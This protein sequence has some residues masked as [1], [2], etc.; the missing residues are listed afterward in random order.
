MALSSRLK[1]WEQKIKDEKKPLPATQPPPSVSVVPGGFL[2]QL[3]RETE[4]ETK[5]K[6]PELKEEKAPSKLS[7]N[8]VQ[9]FLLPD[10]TPPILEAEMALRAEQMVNAALKERKTSLPRQSLSPNAMTQKDDFRVKTPEQSDLKQENSSS[11]LKFSEVLAE[12]KNLK[13]KAEVQLGVKKVKEEKI[14]ELRQEPEGQLADITLTEEPKKPVRDVWYEAET[15]WYMHNNGYTLATQLKPDEG[16]PELPFGKVRVRLHTDGSVHD[17][18][19]YEIEKLNP[20][21]LDLCED[22]S[23]LVS[24]NESSILHTLTTRAKAHMALTHAGPNLLALWPPLATSGKGMRTRHWDTWEAPAPLQALVQTVYMSM[25]GQRKDQCV[26]ALGRSGTGKTTLCQAFARGLLK[27]AGTTGESITLERLQAMF[28]VLHSFGCVSS[29]HSEASSRFAMVLSLDFNHKGLA[30]AGH[31]QTMMLERWRVCHSPEG[32]SNFLI[33]S[34]MLAGLST[35]IRTELQLHQLPENNIF[36]ISCPTKVDEKQ[37]ATVEFGRLLAAMNTLGFSPDEQRAIWHVLAGIYHLGMAGACKVGRKQ[38]MNF[39][40]AQVASAVL[41]CEGED[42]HTAVFKHHLMQLL[43]RATRA[44]RERHIKEEQEEGPKLSA[45]QCVEGMASGLYEE[46]FTIIVSLINR[47]LCSQQLTLGSVIVVDTPGLR[48]PRHSG[49]DRAAGFSEFCHNYLQERL[50]EHHFTNTFTNCLD[51]YTQERV[52]VDF[53]T[54]EESPQKVVCAIDQPGLQV[55]GQEGDSRGLLWVLDEELVTPNSSENTVL[56]KICHNFSDTVRLCEQPLQCEIAHLTGSDPIRYDLSGWFGL[57]QNNPSALNASSILQNS[58]IHVV[59]GLFAPR[60]SVPPLCRGL[61]GVEGGSQRFLERSG[62]VRKTFTGGMAAIRRYSHCISIKLQAD[63][64]INLIRRAQPVFLQCL[65]AKVEGGSFDVPAL[66]TQLQSTHLLPS[67]QLYRLG[68][69]DH[70]SLSDFR[71]H[72]QAL[73]PPVMK[74]Y[75][76]VFITPNER[77]AVEELLIELDMDKKSIVLG[78]NKVFL[79][80]GVLRSL[81]VQRDGLVNNWLVQMQAA[82]FGHLARQRYRHLKVQQMAVRCIQRNLRVLDR[83]STWSWWKV[84]CKVRP[85]LDVNIDEHKVRAKEDEI[86]I[87]RRRLEKSEKERNELRQTADNLE[88]KITAVVSELS[89]E[90]FRGEAVSQALDTE[91]TERLRLIKENKELQDRLDQSK[92]TVEALEKELAEETQRAN[93]KETLSGMAPTE[94]ELQLQL[95]CAQTEV[96]F[97]RRRLRQTDERF[98]AEKEARVLLDTK[99]LELQT[100]VEQSKR[101][102]TELKRH[103]RHVTSDLQ[104]ARVIMDSLQARAHDLERKQRRFDSELTRALE[105]ADNEREQKDKAI[106]ESIAL[107]AD[108]VSLH[109]T[110]KVSQLEIEHL[111][112]QKQELCAQIR[113][114]TVPL[115]LGSDSVPELKK[116]LR[117]FDSRDKERA[118]ELANMKAKIQQQ[119]QIHLRFEMEM[120]RMKQIH[121][122]EL[123]DKDEELEDVQKSSQRRLRQLEMQLEQE[124]EEKQMVVHEKHDLEGLIATLCEQVGHR[125]FDVEKRLRRDLKRTHALL[126]DAQL[127]LSTIEQTG[128]CQVPGTKEQLERLH[129]QL[130][131]SEARRLEAESVQKTLSMEL[132]NAQL[133]LENICKQKSL[134]DEQLTQLQYEKTDFLKRL[135]EDQEDLNELMKKHKA[136]IAQSSSDITQ[137][138]ELQAEL[139]EVKKER[140]SLQEQLQTSAVHLQFL[141]S[142]TVSRS[143]VSKQEARVCDLEN[144]L[145][146]QRGQVKRFEVLVLRLRDSVVRMGEELEQSAQAEARERENSHYYQQRLEDMKLEMEDLSLRE[147]ESSRRRME[148]EMQVEELSAVSQTLQADLETSI[149]RIADLQAALEE[150]ESSDESDTESVQTAVESFSR[151]REMDNASSVGSSIG[152]EDTAKG[153]QHWLGVPRGGHKVCGSRGSSYAGSTTGRQSVTDKMSTYSFRSCS[154]ELEDDVTESARI[155]PRASSSTALSELLEGLRKKRAGWDKSSEVNEGSTVSLPIYQPTA[156]SSLRRRAINLSQDTSESMEETV[157]PGILKVP[158]PLLPRA[159]SLRSLSESTT[160]TSSSTSTMSKANRFGSCDLVTA[161]P[162]SLQISNLSIPEE[163]DEVPGASPGHGTHPQVRNRLFMA[164]TSESGEEAMLGSEPLVFQNRHLLGNPETDKE[165]NCGDTNSD[166]VPAIRRSQSVSSIA[167]SSS[168]G[169]QRRTLS[170]HFGEL[171]PSRSLCKDSDSDSSDSEGSQHRIGPQEKRLEAEGSEGD[172]NSVMKKYLRKAEVD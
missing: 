108:I 1:L 60:A 15:V 165:S 106:Q 81:N 58:T 86:A 42:L 82:C 111:Q 149:R 109:R 41:G 137:I 157:R 93:S 5:L 53:Q 98:E 113:D 160:S 135:E 66:R 148:L 76:S 170:V 166:I 49:K 145:E 123:E 88:T 74:R 12:K 127:L 78:T 138:R 132:E 155:L 29:N 110:L 120:E 90:R 100:Q 27:H 46:L 152:T 102:I 163:R 52:S 162:S 118:Q 107:G 56:E 17:V 22:L 97:L 79:K 119:E 57:V 161:Q 44:T 3:V 54:P 128:Q 62:S 6:E 45:A 18:A 84:L 121:Q 72:F 94:G 168:R 34:Q 147:Q 70:M 146:F 55:R 158:S 64:L 80:C 69:P 71:C 31:L 37:R 87:L 4:K 159:S 39:E 91:R 99:V 96:E 43:Q 130:E 68:Y 83:V 92:V 2:K 63:A 48:N 16:T 105:E 10:E 75:G 124:Y 77:Q 139:E 8:L 13:E 169:G 172:I 67:L 28:T 140:Q 38:F 25:V 131:E 50:L 115:N 11:T 126:S 30:A 134:V 104:D 65:S 26:M 51:R 129:Y 40:S 14:I 133:E 24:V 141:E 73:S 112:E 89:D 7:E 122:K 114:L 154:Q 153:I 144:K 95:D 33:F 136:L 32:E 23:Q 9:Q 36:G 103:C 116:Q 47:A 61:G 20:P 59:K 156:A 19:Q 85:L 151:R 142:S 125:D 21:E 35:E 101:T 117:E 150:E 167:S 143:I 164:L 171:P